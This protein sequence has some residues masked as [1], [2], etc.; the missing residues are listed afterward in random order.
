MR[1]PISRKNSI[2]WSFLCNI[3]LN[4]K[5]TGIC[6][7]HNVNKY[8]IIMRRKR[9]GLHGEKLALIPPLHLLFIKTY[10]M[11]WYWDLNIRYSM[12]NKHARRNNNK[13][14]IR[15]KY[16]HLIFLFYK[17]INNLFVIIISFMLRFKIH[18]Q[19]FLSFI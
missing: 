13:S 12:F 16:F 9:K 3:Y 1:W 6:Q 2:V 15:T 18:F 5:F 4:H 17:F 10:Y 11:F 7:N 19:V 8:F 14:F